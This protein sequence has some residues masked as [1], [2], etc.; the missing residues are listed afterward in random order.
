MTEDITKK[1]IKDSERW[2]KCD[3]INL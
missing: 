3:K 1:I 2:V